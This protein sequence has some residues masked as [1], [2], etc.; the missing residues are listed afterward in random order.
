MTEISVVAQEIAASRQRGVLADEGKLWEKLRLDAERVAAGEEML[1][2]FLDLIVLHHDGFPSAL[3]LLLARKLAEYSMRA[4]QLDEIARAAMAGD[5][6]II[7]AA[8]ADLV[9]IRTRDP[10]AENYLRPFLYY[11]GFH[12]LQWHRISHWLWSDGRRELAHFLQSRVSQFCRRYPSRRAYREWR[13]YRPR[14][15]YQCGDR[16]R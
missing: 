13:V 8:I 7:T 1:R 6:G 15:S 9:A 5:P 4:E 11:K 10:A 12:A 14:Y 16:R 2:G 3:G